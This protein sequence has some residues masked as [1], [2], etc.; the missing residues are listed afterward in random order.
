MKLTKN[1]LIKKLGITDEEIIF[2]VTEYK[3]KLPILTEEGEGF[4]VSARDLHKELVEDDTS[5][6]YNGKVA[7]GDKFSQWIVRRIEKYGFQNGIDFESAWVDSDGHKYVNVDLDVNNVNQMTR[8]GYS[9]EYYITID[10]AKQLAMVQNNEKGKL[11]RKYFI[12]VEKVLKLAI[13]W[14]RIRKPEKEEYKIM[15]KEL[16]LFMQRNYGKKAETHHYTNEADTL[17]KIC[18]GATA[19][20]IKEYIDAQD[21]NTRD[22]LQAKYNLYLSEMQRLNIMYLRMNMNKEI[23][24]NLLKQGFKVTYPEASFSMIGKEAIN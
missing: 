21:E 2:I 18:L 6:T 1:N 11:A 17:N 3:D 22:W 9:K 4:C 20:K 5:K 15:C 12:A 16:D 19:K 24:Y 8:N 14:E 10:M 13:Q 7:K 23:R